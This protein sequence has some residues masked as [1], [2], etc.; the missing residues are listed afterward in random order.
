MRVVSRDFSLVPCLGLMKGL[1]CATEM[2]QGCLTGGLRNGINSSGAHVGFSWAHP[3]MP[4]LSQGLRYF[5]PD[6]SPVP[7]TTP[8]VLP[9][10]SSALPAC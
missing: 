5:P 10:A 3:A 1:C 7:H 9:F 2:V 8:H 4:P 6:S